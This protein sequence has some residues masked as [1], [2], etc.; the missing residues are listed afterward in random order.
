MESKRTWLL[1]YLV[2]S[3]IALALYIFSRNTHIGKTICILVI[4]MQI[5]MLVFFLLVIIFKWNN[6]CRRILTLFYFGGSIYLGINHYI[7]KWYII[8]PVSLLLIFYMLWNIGG[9]KNCI[10]AYK[11][12]IQLNRVVSESKSSYAGYK[13][14]VGQ[15]NIRNGLGFWAKVKT[16]KEPNWKNYEFHSS[17]LSMF[18]IADAL[19]GITTDRW[20][21]QITKV[22]KINTGLGKKHKALRNNESLYE[23]KYMINRI[24]E[25]MEDFNE[26]TKGLDKSIKALDSEIVKSRKKE[27]K[28][29][30]KRW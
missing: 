16:K 2:C 27:K 18:S 29:L 15:Y 19:S 26:E 10:I 30:R 9:V 24:R 11:Y 22:S 21:N 3:S 13:N 8:V 6:G 5:L 28:I 23:E 25:K 1:S 20:E 12:K 17:G 14:G 4:E 7:S